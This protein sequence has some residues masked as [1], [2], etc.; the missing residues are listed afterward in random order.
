MTV[1]ASRDY[2]LR[3]PIV[4]N[5]LNSSSLA[6]EEIFAS[7]MGDARLTDEGVRIAQTGS[8]ANGTNISTS[9]V[10]LLVIFPEPKG[11]D[12]DER[13][14]RWLDGRRLV[15]KSLTDAFGPDKVSATNK[16]LNVDEPNGVS[17][18]VMPVLG[19]TVLGLKGAEPADAIEFWT[20]LDR[21]NHII[22]F[23][24]LHLR[25]GDQKQL[26]T[27]GG[28]KRLVRALKITKHYLVEGGFFN[29]ESA[30]S[31][32]LE[33]L[34]YNLP[35]ERFAGDLVD[36]MRYAIQMGRKAISEGNNLATVSGVHGL[37]GDT[38]LNWKPD[39]A[40]KVFSVYEELIFQTRC[41]V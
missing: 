31:Y 26:E 4:F 18:D 37:F 7:L 10:D 17:F 32:H 25:N 20:Y 40:L 5:G 19:R 8:S 14:L 41:E 3:S 30:Y 28:Y 2:L 11:L 35:N 16:C 23:P 6:T 21:G 33:C 24:W 15:A 34:A 1:T 13:K 38:I 36:S 9:D 12:Q 39:V 29:P 27:A 22:N